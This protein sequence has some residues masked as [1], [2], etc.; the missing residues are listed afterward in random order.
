MNHKPCGHVE[1][2]AFR[3]GSNCSLDFDLEKSLTDALVFALKSWSFDHPE[4]DDLT[5]GHRTR[6]FEEAC[7]VIRNAAYAI[8]YQ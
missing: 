5:L 7:R 6:C 3:D 2:C 1:I 8:A 4:W